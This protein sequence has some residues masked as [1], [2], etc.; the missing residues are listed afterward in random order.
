M[1]PRAGSRIQKAAAMLCVGLL[2][3]LQIGYGQ[4]AQ[5]PAPPPYQAGAPAAPALSPQQLDDLVAPVALYPDPLL[6]EVM[7]ASTYPLEIVEASRWLQQNRNLHGQQLIDAAKQQNWDPSVQAL[8]AFPD[9][10]TL[11]NN[12]IQWTTNL[13]NA[14]LAQQADVMAAVQTMRARAEANGKLNSNSQ[15]VVTTDTQNGQSAIEIQP[16]NPQEIYVPVYQPEYIWG[17]PAWGAYPDLWYPP[18][19]GFDFGFAFLPGIYL[20]GFF[21][22]GT[23]G[24]VGA[25]AAAGLAAACS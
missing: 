9:V 8:V 12:D 15:E 17:P 21:P 4:V 2:S 11:L 1:T 16:A 25:G 18:G 19:Y 3:W 23:A 7:A 24:E 14:F 13:G 22:A 20:G 6:G 5:G 10:L